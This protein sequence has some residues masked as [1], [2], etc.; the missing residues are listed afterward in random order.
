VKYFSIIL[1]CKPDISNHEQIS[2][3]VRIVSVHEEVTIEHFV[4]LVL[5][6]IPQEKY[7]LKG[8]CTF[9]RSMIFLSENCRGQGSDHGQI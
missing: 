8:R 5:Y 6:E 2:V 9:Y 7:C 1:D 3:I 4:Q